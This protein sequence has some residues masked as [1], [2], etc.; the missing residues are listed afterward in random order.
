[1]ARSDE[2]TVLGT[3]ITQ[4]ALFGYRFLESKV[5]SLGLTFKMIASLFKV[6]S[7]VSFCLQRFSIIY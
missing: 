5:K 1:M 3:L 2:A 7:G 4:V 6:M